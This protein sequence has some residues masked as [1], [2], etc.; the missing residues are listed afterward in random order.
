[1]NEL[2][3]WI[4]FIVAVLATWRLTHLFANEDGPADLIVRFRLRLGNRFAG[5]LLDCFYCL[6]FW[7]AAPLAYFV[8]GKP[9]DLVVTWVAL[10]GAACLLQQITAPDKQAPV[11]QEPMLIQLLPQGREGEDNHG[12]LWSETRGDQ[13]DGGGDELQSNR[14]A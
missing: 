4:K 10:S 9:L 12:L 2:N 1:M 13:A 7:V 11:G 3:F 6:S 14:T 8:G 5:K